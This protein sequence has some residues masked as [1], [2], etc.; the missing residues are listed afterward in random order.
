VRVDLCGVRGST[1]A[2]GHGFEQYGGH[3]SCIA[4]TPDGGGKPPLILDA[5][6]GIRDAT[7][8]L[9]GSAFAGTILLTHLHWDHITG[10]PFFAGGDRDDS[11]VHVVVPEQDAGEDPLAVLARAMSPPFFP[12][13]PNLLRGAWSFESLPSG[14]STREG[15]EVL[16]REIPHKGGRTFGFRVSDGRSTITYM[17]DHCP[18]AL[19]RGPDGFGEYHDAA[20]ELAAGSDLL[21]H[22]AQLRADELDAKAV[23]GH[24]C[25]EYAVELARRAGAR[26]VLL[27]HHAPSRSD[28]ELHELAEH[29]S[30][31]PVVTLARQGT[32]LEL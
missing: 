4:I 26:A 27:F 10:M 11:A 16:A 30:G 23:M 15:F 31:E 32:T 9:G 5:G 21:V 22:D 2:P 3:T 12:V 14:E 13:P 1:P 18:R 19:G 25:G 6:T 28:E 8:L 17:P 24:S 29:F 20:L 7:A